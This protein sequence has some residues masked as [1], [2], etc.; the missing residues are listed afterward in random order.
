VTAFA[1]TLVHGPTELRGLRHLLAS[2]LEQTG[3]SADVRDAV[4]LATHEAAANAVSHGEPEG[5]VTVSAV[6]DDDGSFSVEVTNHGAWKKPKAGHNGR[7]LLM[8]TQ[9]MSDV[10]I[11]TSVRMHRGGSRS[12]LEQPNDHVDQDGDDEGSHE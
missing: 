6:Q 5:P 11:R 2:W 7:G 4:V 12:A 8:M 3:A 9:L 1:A 10:G